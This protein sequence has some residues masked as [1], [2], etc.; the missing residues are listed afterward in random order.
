MKEPG[1]RDT[2]FR[3]TGAPQM[4]TALY[5]V[6]GVVLAVFLAVAFVLPGMQ[7]SERRAAAAALVAGTEPAKKQVAAAAEKAGSLSG[8]GNG[9]T[10]G[11]KNDPGFG[12]LKWI[13]DLNGVIRGWGG[14]SAIE[15]EV[16]PRLESGKVSWICRGYPVASMPPSCGG[17]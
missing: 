1:D 10:L 6:A 17:R 12:E 15:I 16:R 7:G 3:D 4:R 13:V 5:I 11:P 8:S 2:L 9:V 14:R